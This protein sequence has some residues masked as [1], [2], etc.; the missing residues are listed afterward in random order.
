MILQGGV[1]VMRAYGL[2]DDSEPKTT[3]NTLT[4]PIEARTQYRTHRPFGLGFG[5]RL[6]L[7]PKGSIGFGFL[8]MRFGGN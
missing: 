2:F 5:F 3:E 6:N 1:G 8:S 4:F 7:T